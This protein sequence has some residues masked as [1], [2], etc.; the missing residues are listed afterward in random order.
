VAHDD[1]TGQTYSD[2]L[3][4]SV[5]GLGVAA[6]KYDFLKPVQ[7]EWK[8]VSSIQPGALIDKT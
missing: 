4:Q 3:W 6:G 7:P 2:K 5:R 8:V 1:P